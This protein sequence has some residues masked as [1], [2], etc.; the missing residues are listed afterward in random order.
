MIRT[1]TVLTMNPGTAESS[2]TKPAGLAAQDPHKVM[3]R[4][5][6]DVDNIVLK[7]LRKDRRGGTLR[8][9]S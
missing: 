4:L 5:R 9:S 2:K 1:D 6:G 3:R 7:A 8:R